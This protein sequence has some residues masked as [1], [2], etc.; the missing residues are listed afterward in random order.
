GGAV[1][2]AMRAIKDISLRFGGVQALDDVT[3]SLK[4]GEILGLIGPNGAGK[5]TLFNCVS[6]VLKPNN[7][8]ITYEGQNLAGLKTDARAR[9][10]IGRTFQ[11]LHLFGSLTVLENLMVPR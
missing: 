8:A 11:N 4:H 7:G 10:G 1:A 3:F 9:L 6:G 5:T 2:Q